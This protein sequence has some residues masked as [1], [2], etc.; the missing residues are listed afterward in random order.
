MSL[1]R[2]VFGLGVA[3]GI[4]HAQTQAEA[5]VQPAFEAASV[6]ALPSGTRMGRPGPSDPGRFSGQTSLQNLIARA[7]RVDTD[8]VKGPDWIGDETY[9]VEANIPDGATQEQVDTMLRN[10]LLERFRMTLHHETKVVDGYDLMVAD[11]G[12]KLKEVAPTATPGPQSRIS[13]DFGQVGITINCE[14][15]PMSFFAADL[16]AFRVGTPKARVRVIDKTGLTGAYDFNLHYEGRSASPPPPGLD[17]FGA[18]EGQLGLR[19]QAA[20]ITVDIVV[21]DRAEK[22]PAEN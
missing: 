10:L 16:G 15:V 5:T 4:L 6:Q 21:V 19:L 20:K 18:V 11:G 1:A 22:V 3:G 13:G 7:Y 9:S 17:I 12:P 14:S 8:Q 2:I